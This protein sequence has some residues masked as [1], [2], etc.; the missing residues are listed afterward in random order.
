MVFLSLLEPRQI[1]DSVLLDGFDPVHAF[2]N[3]FHGSG[4]REAQVSFPVLAEIN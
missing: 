1:K 3:F 2:G 4:T